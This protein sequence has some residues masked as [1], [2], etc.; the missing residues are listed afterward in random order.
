M[1]IKNRVYKTE[2]LIHYSN[3]D[4]QNCNG[5]YQKILNKNSFTCSMTESY[6]PNANAIAERV[7]GIIKQEFIEYDSYINLNL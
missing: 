2:S 5:D 6:D 7:K 3:R 4:L 1:A